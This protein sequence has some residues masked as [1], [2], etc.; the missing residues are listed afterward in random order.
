M[1]NNPTTSFEVS[2]VESGDR[3]VGSMT[4]NKDKV[5]TFGTIAV[6]RMIDK[7]YIRIAEVSISTIAPIRIGLSMSPHDVP[8][9]DVEQ[10]IV[11]IR[12]LFSNVSAKLETDILTI[13]TKSETELKAL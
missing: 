5:V 13:I 10:R 1:I 12:P 4:A 11:T 9:S 2:S 6:D 8:L 7:A 3:Y